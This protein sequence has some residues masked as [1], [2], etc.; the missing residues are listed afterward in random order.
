V[1]PTGQVLRGGLPPSCFQEALV[2]KKLSLAK[3]LAKVLGAVAVV[4]ARF[5]I[6]Q[7][8]EGWGPFTGI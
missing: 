5:S 7:C 4:A 3:D 1:K 8:V 2:S 6:S